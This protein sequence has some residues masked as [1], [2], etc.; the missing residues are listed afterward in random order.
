MWITIGPLTVQKNTTFLRNERFSFLR[1]TST[2]IF[3]QIP[4]LDLLKQQFPVTLVILSLAL[5]L[6]NVLQ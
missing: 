3:N 5:L 1:L 2:V 4:E 6:T